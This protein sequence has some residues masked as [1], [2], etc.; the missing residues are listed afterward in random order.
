MKAFS[1]G[2]PTKAKI[3]RML[4]K[5]KRERVKRSAKYLIF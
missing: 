5:M 3:K 2:E 4:A 1:A